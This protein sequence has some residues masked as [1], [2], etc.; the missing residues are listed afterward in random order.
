MGISH[1]EFRLSTS[2]KY[3]VP[4]CIIKHRTIAGGKLQHAALTRWRLH[5]SV[6]FVLR[7]VQESRKFHDSPVILK[8]CE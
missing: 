3:T 7:G 2:I 8:Y 6:I 5:K 4:S 1:L